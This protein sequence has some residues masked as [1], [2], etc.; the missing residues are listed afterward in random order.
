MAAQNATLTAAWLKIADSADSAVLIQ[1][2]GYIEYQIAAMATE[3]APNS[4]P[5]CVAYH[6]SHSTGAAVCRLNSNLPP[7]DCPCS[8]YSPDYGTYGPRLSRWSQHLM[9]DQPGDLS[10]RLKSPSL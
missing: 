4:K 5:P 2:S 9:W 6:L 3:A 1:A 7:T 10:S 8:D